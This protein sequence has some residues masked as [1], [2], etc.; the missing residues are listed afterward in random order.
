MALQHAR[1]LS[2]EQ[3]NN[4]T[5]LIRRVSEQDEQFD[6]ADLHT[7]YEDIKSAFI[8]GMLEQH[9]PALTIDGVAAFVDGYVG[10]VY[11]QTEK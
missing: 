10:T 2:R 7:L 11:L 8:A 9:I 6:I 5:D 4:V 3:V 1:P